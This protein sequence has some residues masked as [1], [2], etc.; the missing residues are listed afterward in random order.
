[1]WSA[2]SCTPSGT[3]R[4]RPGYP[5]RVATDSADVVL[6]MH[7]LYHVEDVE[8]GIRELARVLSPSGT[9]FVSTNAIEDKSELDNLWRRAASQVLD[10]P[11]PLSEYRCPAGFH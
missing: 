2:V 11:T 5:C 9:A 1:M 4:S 8:A 3:R 10:T 6:A 7:M